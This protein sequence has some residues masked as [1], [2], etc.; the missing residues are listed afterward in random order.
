MARNGVVAADR[1]FREYGDAQPPGDNISALPE[2]SIFVTGS[3]EKAAWV[4]EEE[5]DSSEEK[6]V[7]CVARWLGLEKALEL[8]PEDLAA[9][10]AQAR[11]EAREFARQLSRLAQELGEPHAGK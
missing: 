3:W 4:R 6:Q 1:A 11:G 7:E 10:F 5:M 8:F 2:N 9:S